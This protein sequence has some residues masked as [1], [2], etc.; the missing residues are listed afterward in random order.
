MKCPNCSNEVPETANVC[1]YCGQ[2]LKSAVP[3]PLSTQPAAK[4]GIT[5]RFGTL[6]LGAVLMSLSEAL[7]YFKGISTTF[8]DTPV[9]ILLAF[10]AFVYWQKGPRGLGCFIGLIWL[11]LLATFI[12][13]FL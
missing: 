13:F 7:W 12:F 10:A 5:W 4:I 1:G 9:L 8:L 6:L 3:P 2:R 11:G